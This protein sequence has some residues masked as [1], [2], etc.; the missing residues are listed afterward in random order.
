MNNLLED[1]N[2]L[3][4]IDRLEKIMEEKHFLRFLGDE[5][6]DGNW[7][8][9]GKSW[10]VT[11]RYRC[12]CEKVHSGEVTIPANSKDGSVYQVPS[13]CGETTDL[14]IWRRPPNRS[15]EN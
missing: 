10:L 5:I 1:S 14:K 11:F 13:P 6:T 12:K 15:V 2:V 9:D 8:S 3:S 7:Q 4:R